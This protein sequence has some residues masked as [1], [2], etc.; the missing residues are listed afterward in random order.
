MDKKVYEAIAR[1]RDGFLSLGAIGEELD[2][3]VSGAVKAVDEKDAIDKA[4]EYN[5]NEIEW[6]EKEGQNGFYEYAQASANP[7]NKNYDALVEEL[8]RSDNK[9]FISGKFYWLFTD[10]KAVGRKAVG[11]K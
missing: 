10:G 11:K 1:I 7:N 4:F 5:P 6:V 2:I 8:K 3:I 9:K